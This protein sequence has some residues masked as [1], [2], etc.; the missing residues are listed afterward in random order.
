MRCIWKGVGEC[1]ARAHTAEANA[2]AESQEVAQ[3]L[4]Q[5]WG[6][7]PQRWMH[8]HLH[9]EQH[10]T[11]VAGTGHGCRHGTRA[12]AWSD[13]HAPRTCSAAPLGRVPSL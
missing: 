3:P 11:H 8:R 5:L 12:L 6:D 9:E 4:L 13:Q 2:G 7:V 1:N 10:T